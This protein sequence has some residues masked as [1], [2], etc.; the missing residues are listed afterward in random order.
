MRRS[1]ARKLFCMFR[2]RSILRIVL[3]CTWSKVSWQHLL[4]CNMRLSLMLGKWHKNIFN[5]Y[6]FWC[7]TSGITSGFAFMWSLSFQKSWEEPL[8][9]LNTFAN[10]EGQANPTEL[11]VLYRG[12]M[13]EAGSVWRHPFKGG[14]LPSEGLIFTS[15]DGTV[16]H[17]VAE[18]KWNLV[19]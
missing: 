10:T 15:L 3:M 4:Q 12:R 17:F 9:F 1:H 8:P 6:M 13:Q 16:S 5:I 14:I 2:N 11:N 18:V 19:N 7:G